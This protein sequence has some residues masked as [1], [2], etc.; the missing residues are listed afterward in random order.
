MIQTEIFKNFFNINL[1]IE[2]ENNISN[3]NVFKVTSCF[4]VSVNLGWNLFLNTK[5]VSLFKKYQ[6]TKILIFWSFSFLSSQLFRQGKFFDSSCT[7]VNG[8][9]TSHIKLFFHI[10]C[11]TDWEWL[12]TSRILF[13]DIFWK[14]K[15]ILYLGID[16]DPN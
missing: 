16:C 1:Q 8:G 5:F 2:F 11:A 12:Q 10:T 7:R 6:L 14:V 4:K 9:E 3:I 15:Q 13:I